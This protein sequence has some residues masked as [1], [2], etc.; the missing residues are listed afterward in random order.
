MRRPPE[1]FSKTLTPAITIGPNGGFPIELRATETGYAIAARDSAPRSSLSIS[2]RDC[3][4]ILTRHN[5]LNQPLSVA[6][7]PP[8]LENP[9]AR[10]ALH[11]IY[12]RPGF[13]NLHHDLSGEHQ[14]G[15]G[16][17]TVGFLLS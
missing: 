6:L 17:P 11:S 1:Q 3:A 16:L 14:R 4:P 8:G 5:R 9:K 2:I 13:G 12:H 10:Q 7:K 15:V